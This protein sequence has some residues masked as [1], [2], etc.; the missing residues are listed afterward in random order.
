MYRDYH[1]TCRSTCTYIYNRDAFHSMSPRGQLQLGQLRNQQR[2]LLVV[3]IPVRVHTRRGLD[4]IVVHQ[5]R[6]DRQRFVDGDSTPGA[7][8]RTLRERVPIEGMVQ[9]LRRRSL[10]RLQP[11][12]QPP[13]G[14]ELGRVVNDGRV[15]P[16]RVLIKGEDAALL[17]F[18]AVDGHGIVAVALGHGGGMDGGLAMRFSH[19]GVQV[20]RSLLGQHLGRQHSALLLHV[21][22]HF[23]VQLLLHVGIDRQMHHQPRNKGRGGIDAGVQQQDAYVLELVGRHGAVLGTESLDRSGQVR[24]LLDIVQLVAIVPLNEAFDL[25][26]GSFVNRIHL[27]D[28]GFVQLGVDARLDEQTLPHV[29]QM[30]DQQG[31][32]VDGR[33]TEGRVLRI[34]RGVGIRNFRGSSEEDG[35]EHVE[36]GVVQERIERPPRGVGRCRP[37]RHR[38]RLGHSRHVSPGGLRRQQIGLQE[39]PQ[40]P[41]RLP[42]AEESQPVHVGFVAG[43]RQRHAPAAGP[44]LEGPQSLDAAAG[45]AALISQNLEHLVRIGQDDRLAPRSLALAGDA[46]LVKVAVEAAQERVVIVGIVDRGD[47]NAVVFGEFGADERNGAEERAEYWHARYLLEGGMVD[48]I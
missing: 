11:L 34:G 13:L 48:G 39:R 36:C 25:G 9:H 8:P 45:M 4:L 15:H 5:L 6:Q 40:P 7:A 19:R 2:H 14:S 38:G 32:R 17:E 10:G 33:R 12:R 42:S 37:A 1:S 46:D 18:D 20:R 43:A 21:A 47:G 24:C 31:Q 28:E 30:L 41:P 26:L 27:L 44:G 35:I 23:V 3:K 22:P 29:E 16:G